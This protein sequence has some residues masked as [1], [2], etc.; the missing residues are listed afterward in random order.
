[1]FSRHIS[2]NFHKLSQK[3]YK[4]TNIHLYKGSGMSGRSGLKVSII[5]AT[6]VNAGRVI[7]SFLLNGYPTVMA[8][9]RP[10]D[11]ICPIGDDVTFN[12]SNPYNS[13]L[14]FILNMDV[15]NEVSMNK[16]ES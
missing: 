13:W 6:A 14:P 5:G 10:I 1:M 15:I 4:M 3:G 11:V 2:S 7:D 9:R 12:K 8:H 16:L